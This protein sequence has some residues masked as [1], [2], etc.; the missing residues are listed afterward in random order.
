[1]LANAP[2]DLPAEKLATWKGIHNRLASLV[3][4]SRRRAADMRVVGVRRIRQLA[5]PSIGLA[6]QAIAELL[7]GPSTPDT[8]TLLGDLLLNAG[9]VDEARESYG[10]AGA[11]A[12]WRVR[13]CDWAA[14]TFA[15][16]PEM[17]ADSP[18][19]ARRYEALRRRL[20]GAEITIP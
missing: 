19:S 2:A 13:L 10:R 7:A 17:P 4:I 3:G 18:A 15:A 8:D 14:G 16:G 1:M 6:D 20:M 12:A 5:S 9:R 11:K